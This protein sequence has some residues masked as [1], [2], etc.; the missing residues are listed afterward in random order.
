MFEKNKT[1]SKTFSELNNKQKIKKMFVS[2]SQNWQ[3]EQ[4]KRF[5]NHHYKKQKQKKNKKKFN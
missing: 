5:A 1:E 2:S 4:I 3:S